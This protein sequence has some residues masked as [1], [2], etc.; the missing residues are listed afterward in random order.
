MGS[1]AIVCPRSNRLAECVTPGGSP[2]PPPMSRPSASAADPRTGRS[3]ASSHCA[4]TCSP[5]AAGSA[6]ARGPNTTTPQALL[7]RR[8]RP[9]RPCRKPGSRRRLIF[10]RGRVSSRPRACR[11]ANDT[12][13]LAPSRTS[14]PSRPGCAVRLVDDLLPVIG[15]QTRHDYARLV[16]GAGVRTVTPTTSAVDGGC[17]EGG[18]VRR[19]LE[20]SGLPQRFIGVVVGRRFHSAVIA[21]VGA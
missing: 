11:K 2:P 9:C 1:P 18:A 12:G 13:T 16:T 21:W 19:A 15:R 14:L 8:P 3:G 4:S 20:A 17:W 5:P 10:R 6:T 7:P